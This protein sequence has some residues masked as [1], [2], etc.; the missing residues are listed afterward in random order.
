M[1]DL[2]VIGNLGETLPALLSLIEQRKHPDW[3]AELNVWREDSG[4]TDIINYEVDELIPPYVIRQLWHSTKDTERGPAIIVTDVGQHQMWESQYFV[5]EFSGQLLT[6][7]G[8]G[9][10]GYA[11]CSHR[12][13]WPTRQT[14]VGRGGRRRLPDDAART[15]CVEAGARSAREDRHHQQRVLGMVRQ[16]QQLFYERRYVGTPI[17]ARFRQAGGR[18]GIP[19]LQCASRKMCPAPL[20][21]RLKRRGRF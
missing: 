12:R 16:W 19:A 7:G 20:S 5:H 21:R 3:L 4:Q 17:I 11:A 1:P 13:R 8:L 2:P 10:M 14:G 6:S 9:T 15:G 18:H